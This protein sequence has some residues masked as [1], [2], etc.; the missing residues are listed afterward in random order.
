VTAPCECGLVLRERTVQ[1]SPGVSLF[2]ASTTGRADSVLLV[3]HGGPDWDHSYL[4]EPLSQLADRHRVVLPD[5]RGCGR[6]SQ[7]LAEADYTPDAVVGDLLALADELGARRFSLLGFSWGGLIA[8]RVAVAV[9]DRVEHLIIASSGVLP[10]DAAA[11]GQW[12]E[13]E[14]RRAAEASVWA[15]TS[16]AGPQLTR[17]AAV[18]AAPANVWRAEALP[19]YLLRLADVQFSAEWLRPWQAGIL[20][21]ARLEHPIAQLAATGVPILLLHGRHDMTFPV[22]GVQRAAAM[23]PS[24]QAVV[25]EEA[26]HMAHVDQPSAWLDAIAH[27]LG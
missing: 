15:D 26:G 17:A 2:V 24:C 27:F 19:G 10:V 8:Q 9:P 18:G 20:P 12:P 22:S 4:R 7:G 5:L 14:E 1:V 13:R 21:P 23:L 16:L 3:V 25:L 11:F 6:S